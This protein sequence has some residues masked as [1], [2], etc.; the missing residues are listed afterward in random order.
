MS[1]IS[2]DVAGDLRMSGQLKGSP[3][4]MAAAAT[5]ASRLSVRGSATGT[6][7]ARVQVLGLPKA[8]SATIL[9]QGMLDGAPLN[10][11]AA[12]DRSADHA[13]RVLVRQA[14]WKSAHLDGDMTA[15]ADLAHSHGQLHL[16][17]A[18]LIDL[19]RLV[20]MNLGDRGRN[21]G[22]CVCAGSPGGSSGIGW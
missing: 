14:D 5:I 18:Q 22:D 6:V 19:D 8:S 17:V 15:D 21:F 1:R 4:S 13:F 7:D 2:S 3:G 11:D 16:H 12:V 9:A 10:L 20:G